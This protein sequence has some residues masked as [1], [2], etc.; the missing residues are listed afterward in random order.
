MKTNSKTQ[1]AIEFF[2]RMESLG[3]DYSTAQR[4]RRI[5]M[6]LHRWNEL[7]CGDERGRCIER[8]EA[9]N[10]PFMTYDKGRNGERG[11]YQIPDKEAGALKRLAAIMAGF[12]ALWF[13]R[14][15]DP[16]GCALYVGRKADIA[17]DTP[18]NAQYYRGIAL[19][20]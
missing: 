2:R 11:R 15:G 6:T 9:T 19:C 17:P 18:I 12:P 3:I 4:L 1:R 20:F 13:Y 5:E 16:R 10:V 14:Q 7:E 8:D